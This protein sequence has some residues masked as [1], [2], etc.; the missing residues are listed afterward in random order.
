MPRLQRLLPGL[1]AFGLVL[2]AGRAPAQTTSTSTLALAM[3]NSVERP[4]RVD[5]TLG[6]NTINHRDCVN[7]NAMDFKVTTTNLGGNHIEAW[8]GN[9]DCSV[10]MARTDG[11]CWQVQ[12][13]DGAAS[14]TLP[15][16]VRAIVGHHKPGETNAWPDAAPAT[17]CEDATSDLETSVT[18]YFLLVS[19][20]S[21]TPSGFVPASYEIKYDLMGPDAPTN[22]SSGIGEDSLVV[23]FDASEGTDLNGYNLY[24]DPP[25]SG[26]AASADAGTTDSG[27]AGAGGAS[28]SPT[29]A[30]GAS[31]CPSSVLVEGATANDAYLCGKI[32]SLAESGQTDD[33]LSNGQEYT[34]AVAAVDLYGNPG[35]LSAPV[36]A[37]PEPVTGFY[38][39]YRA[40]G[41]KGGGGFCAIAAPAR[42]SLP[43]LSA[44]AALFAATTLRRR[45]RPGRP[46]RPGRCGR[47]S[48]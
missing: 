48:S 29:A 16:Q 42:A 45:A 21:T 17:D 4:D 46:G 26:A 15:I 27:A 41:G 6:L 12:S 34:V 7:D 14:L 18:I 2:V 33:K 9:T 38:E 35:K 28:S 47:S 5:D 22:V 3:P 37:T 23:D 36:C 13:V 44:I 1:A 11:S 25:P 43:W 32:E 39:A 10:Q 20:T 8:V 19:S 30:A 40:S 31:N 24:C